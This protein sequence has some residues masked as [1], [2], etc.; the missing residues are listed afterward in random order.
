MPYSRI[1][2]ALCLCL[3]LSACGIQVSRIPADTLDQPRAEGPLPADMMA[4]MERD[5]RDVVTTIH[6]S[7]TG[8]A[9]YRGEKFDDYRVEG[10]LLHREPTLRDRYT[11]ES[12]H[13][14]QVQVMAKLNYH[15][16][17]YD[18][19]SQRVGVSN[20]ERLQR[21]DRLCT[22]DSARDVYEAGEVVVTDD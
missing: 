5:I 13:C 4:A 8:Q 22:Y 12:Y 16:T 17:Y 10:R 2:P 14:S 11:G 19:E 6:R 18:R 7:G 15:R 9:V 21:T 3:V 1:P 20:R